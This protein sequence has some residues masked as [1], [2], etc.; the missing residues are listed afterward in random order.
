M[1]ALAIVSVPLLWVLTRDPRA[2]L[3]M[4]ATVAASVATS[5]LIALW[6]GRPAA[7]GDFKARGK[8]NFFANVLETLNGFAWAG[9][10]YLLLNVRAQ[11]ESSL[12]MLLATIGL[13]AIALTIL[14]FGWRSRAGDN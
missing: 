5:A 1:P 9:L 8:G 13:L 12:P 11:G 4:G 3:L 14:F 6:C 2:A 10:A 7:R